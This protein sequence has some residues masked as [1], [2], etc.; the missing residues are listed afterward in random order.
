MKLKVLPVLL[1]AM[2]IM[3]SG[4]GKLVGDSTQTEYGAL[5]VTVAIPENLGL[6]TQSL[7]GIT[8][9]RVWVTVQK[10]GESKENS[11]VIDNGTAEILFPDITTGTWTVTAVVKD[12]EGYSILTGQIA[13]QWRRGSQPQLIC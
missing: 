2:A 12:T 6:S 10:N 5:K 1:L 3:F 13:P 11:A 7:S 9:D 4:C 8:L